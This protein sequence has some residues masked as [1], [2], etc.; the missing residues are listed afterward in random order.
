MKPR[1]ENMNRQSALVLAGAA[2]VLWGAYRR[3]K[4][5][6]MMETAADWDAIDWGSLW[7]TR[8]GQVSGAVGGLHSK[9]A[10]G[11]T[12]IIGQVVAENALGML[13][14]PDDDVVEAIAERIGRRHASAASV[15]DSL[16]WRGDA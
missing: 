15:A 9:A 5:V 6:A 2:C 12:V 10:T 13:L 1:L 4:T 7:R 14:V 16:S 3:R 8:R 11:P